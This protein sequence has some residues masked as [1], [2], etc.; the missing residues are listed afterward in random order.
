M[1]D[2]ILHYTGRILP[3]DEVTIAG[4]ATSVMKDLSALRFMVPI[5]D[6]HS[7][8]AYSI[9]IQIHSHHPTAKH[10]GVETTWRYVLQVA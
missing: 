1:K 7:P 8:L 2:D 9:V 10:S 3:A 4:R 6:R 5:V